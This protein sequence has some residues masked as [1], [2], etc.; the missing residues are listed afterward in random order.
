[1]QSRG[2]PDILGAYRGRAIGWEAKRPG[3]TATEI[4]SYILGKMGVAGAAVGVIHG[5]DE[6]LQILDKID[7]E[8]EGKISFSCC[9]E[10][11]QTEHSQG[12][13]RSERSA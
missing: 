2:L 8:L 10:R 6:A 1:M 13:G 12:Q 3:R 5:V 4:Q 9:I 7:E 11:P